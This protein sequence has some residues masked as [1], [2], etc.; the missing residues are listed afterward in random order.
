MRLIRTCVAALAVSLLVGVPTASAASISIHQK[1]RVIDFGKSTKVT[2]HLSANPN[3]NVQVE[4]QSK[5]Y[6]YDQPFQ[7]EATKV[8]DSKGNYA[9]TARPDRSTRFR[10]VV[11]QGGSPVSGQVPIYVNGIPTTKLH[12]SGGTVHATMS[13]AFSPQLDTSIFT[14][15][16]LHW[17]FQL[18]GKH[19]KVHRVKTNKTHKLAE[20]K[21][22]G[23]LKY[24]LPSSTGKKKFNIFWCF[25][26][27]K[28]GDVGVGDPA[29]SFKKCP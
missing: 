1:K 5:P 6:P 3:K 14:G 11:V 21:I 7:R 2:G 17:Y 15:V 16:A 18:V 19:N 23:S 9:F 13:F 26:P 29:K 12:V 4:L 24:K 28:H 20:G 25:R 10:V 27:K 22:G 8:T